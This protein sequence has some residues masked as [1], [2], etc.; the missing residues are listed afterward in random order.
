L[1]LAAVRY[2]QRM[3]GRRVGGPIRVAVLATALAA[4]LCVKL[5][6]DGPQKS[7]APAPQNVRLPQTMPASAPRRFEA[8]QV[9][10]AQAGSQG[11]AEPIPPGLV[12]NSPGTTL[13][14]LSTM[15]L[16]S[17]PH[18]REAEA[19]AVAARALAYQA[20]FYPNPTLG[21]ASPQ[22]AGNQTQYNAYVI[23]DLVTKGKIGL[24]R[25]A[26][27]RLAREAEWAL[28]RARFEVVTVVRQRFYTAL[29][30]QQRVKILQGMVGIARKSLNIGERLLKNDLGTRADILLL[31]IEL[32]K[33]EAELRNALTLSETGR[34][35]LAAA[36]GQF[37][38]KI[39]RVE[40]NLKER[41]PDYEMI[42]VQRG[43]I[44]RNA[45][46]RS[47]EVEIARSQ[48]VLR[49]AEVEPFPNLNMMGGY[50]NELSGSTAPQN[51]AI[52]Q[53]QM[54]IPLWNR[55]QGN[56]RAAQAGV[57]TAVAQW[58]RV[59]TELANATAAALGRYQTA[60]QLAERY[61]REILPG[62]VRLQDISLTLYDNGEI[63]FL[64][65]LTAQRALLDANLAY[66]TARESSWTAAAELAGLLQSERFP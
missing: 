31:Q 18:I 3:S 30:A 12:E 28:V 27:E 57:S 17:N 39:A 13:D 21:T 33:A 66:I 56:I 34:R 62:A 63:G 4:F 48:Y 47:A 5:L 19:Q 22:L 9:S 44:A 23:Q 20:G 15:A 64:N 65:Y 61:E 41:L 55:N 58:N 26:A 60:R 32:S 50:Q 35:Q 46:A 54:V 52:Y 43:V 7:A 51:Q 24:N 10:A 16:A 1:A 2:K 29:A 25:G 42:A 6:A 38:M 37:E 8:V 45:L 40:G 14:E 36:T 53:V 11:P 59:Q 49:R